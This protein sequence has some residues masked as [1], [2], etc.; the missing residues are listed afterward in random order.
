MNIIRLYA[1]ILLRR[2][3]D[4]EAD[5]SGGEADEEEEDDEDEEQLKE[6][7]RPR[8]TKIKSKQTYKAMIG[9]MLDLRGP[10]LFEGCEYHWLYYQIIGLFNWLNAPFY[11]SVIY[12]LGVIALSLGVTQK[13]L[14]IPAVT[15][16][17]FDTVSKS[18]MFIF[19]AIC[20]LI[21]AN[22][23]PANTIYVNM[24][25]LAPIFDTLTTPHLCYLSKDVK[26][27]LGDSNLLQVILFVMFNNIIRY[28][29]VV[30]NF[31]QFLNNFSFLNFALDFLCG[32]VTW[33]FIIG[34]THVDFYIRNSYGCYIWAIKF[35]LETRFARFHKYRT[36]RLIECYR[37]SSKREETSS[38]TDD[39][40]TLDEPSSGLGY[41]FFSMGVKNHK[42]D[43]KFI[44]FDEIQKSLNSMDDHL[45]V[46]RST[47]TSSLM[48]I[49]INE[50]LIMGVFAL[51]IYSL[52]ADEAD[53]YHGSILVT[54]SVC[55]FVII[56]ASYFGDEWLS[57]SLAKLLQS[58]EDEY[59]L[60]GSHEDDDDEPR[61]V[62]NNFSHYI[63]PA[64]V[65]PTPEE[66]NPAMEKLIKELDF[67]YES[68][69]I[70]RKDILFCREFLPQF[71]AHLA[72]PWSR[73]SFKSQLNMLG[74]FATLITAKIVFDGE[75]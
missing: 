2:V 69:L 33:F 4:S 41:T 10:K 52:F 39:N 56:S 66:R 29:L 30:D 40:T 63:C 60:Q 35:N 34:T 26:F 46:L 67:L 50:L 59:F 38:D 37:L 55:Y 44:T 65:S 36:R 28:M 74:T 54:W 42:K 47:Q 57:H 12:K 61:M 24:F 62:P 17:L 7:R 20:S 72:T 75:H 49:E 48:W 16:G 73:R 51:T 6:V 23:G 71:E 70:K 11:L 32:S 3:M 53:Y 21:T 14:I 25:R 1:N 8:R 19:L 45:E 15:S 9:E 64:Q 5:S 43:H 18:P 13:R 31:S 27:Q 58:V 68:L 22:L